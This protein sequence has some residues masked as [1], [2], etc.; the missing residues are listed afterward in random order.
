MAKSHSKQKKWD[1]HL[2]PYQELVDDS[3]RK[4]RLIGDEPL[5][6]EFE[7]EETRDGERHDVIE[8]VEKRSGQHPI[9]PS[10]DQLPEGM[11]TAVRGTEG[12]ASDIRTEGEDEETGGDGERHR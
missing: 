12:D 9:L 3:E 1:K 2:L 10:Q 8:E 6:A 5:E 4:I 11:E 7:A